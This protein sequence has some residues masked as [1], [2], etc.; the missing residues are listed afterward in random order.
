MPDFHPEEI[1]QLRRAYTEF[2]QIK[3]EQ[4][5]SAFGEHYKLRELLKRFGVNE[6]FES[7]S[8]IENYIEWVITYGNKPSV[9]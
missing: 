3:S 8:Q 6:K 7:S 2:C 1:T 4:N 5:G 9:F